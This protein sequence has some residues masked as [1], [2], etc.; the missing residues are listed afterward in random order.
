MAFRI[1]VE[2]GEAQITT[3]YN[4]DFVSRIKNAGGKWNNNKKVWEVAEDDVEYA[5]SIMRDVYGRDDSEPGEMVD[6]QLTFKYEYGATCEPYVV[7]GKV[8][9]RAYGRDG[10]AHGGDDVRFIKGGPIA[11]GSSRNWKSAVEA[12]SVVILKNV[13]KRMSEQYSPDKDISVKIIQ[14]KTTKENLLKQKKKL[15][16]QLKSV[17]EQLKE[18]E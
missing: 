8:V 4:P 2:D 13:P 17:N 3:P 14:H 1:D 5:R 10:Y 12:G 6:V 9:S 11:S 18:Y 7:L 15:E 16:E